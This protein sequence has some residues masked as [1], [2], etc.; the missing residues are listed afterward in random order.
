MH[1]PHPHHALQLPPHPAARVCAAHPHARSFVQHKIRSAKRAARSELSVSRGEWSKGGYA[2][3]D[4]LSTAG[5]TDD[6][7]RIH[8]SVRC[9]GDHSVCDVLPVMPQRNRACVC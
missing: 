8:A 9:P 5:I 4:I 3:S 7:E 1:R 6:V 2:A